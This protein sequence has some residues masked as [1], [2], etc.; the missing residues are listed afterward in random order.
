MVKT[1]SCLEV[2]L[3]K[4]NASKE[5]NDAPKPLVDLLGENL[6]PVVQ[7]TSVLSASRSS[8]EFP[9]H[10]A[11]GA[12]SPLFLGA[13]CGYCCLWSCSAFHRSC[14]PSAQTFNLCVVL[15]GGLFF[16]RCFAPSFVAYPV[17]TLPLMH[18]FLADALRRC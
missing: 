10:G 14:D 11:C 2:L 12:A 18:S 17:D 15:R 13:T 7:A 16:G 4:T 5:G 6:V 8:L 9:S 1:T 3:P